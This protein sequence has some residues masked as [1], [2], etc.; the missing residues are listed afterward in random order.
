MGHRTIRFERGNDKFLQDLKKLYGVSV[1]AFVNRL[2]AAERERRK[3]NVT[4]PD[5]KPFTPEN[6]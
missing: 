5:A 2:V 3:K 1:N 4:P 6:G